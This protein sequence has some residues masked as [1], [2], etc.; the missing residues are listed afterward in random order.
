[1]GGVVNDLRIVLAANNSSFSCK[2]RFSGGRP[3]GDKDKA[4]VEVHAAKAGRPGGGV[5]SLRFSHLSV[6][7]SARFF[8]FFFCF[9]VCEET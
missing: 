4:S 8:S 3:A 5:G 2:Q 7:S 9:V 1:M 6:F